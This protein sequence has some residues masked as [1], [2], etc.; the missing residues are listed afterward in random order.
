MVSLDLG[1]FW[2]ISAVEILALVIALFLVL[3]AFRG[4]RKTQSRSLLAGAIGFGILGVASL[5]E[6]VFYDLLGFSLI[7]AQALRSTL[8]AIGFVILL[9]S[10]YKTR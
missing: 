5:V 9:Y 7:E 8:T 3:L 4:Y 6:G 2:Y 1:L 10:I